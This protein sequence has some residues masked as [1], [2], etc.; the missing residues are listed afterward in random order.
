MRW[1]HFFVIVLFAGAI[2]V[3][4]AQNFQIVTMSFFGLSA[5]LP[6]AVLAVIIYLAGTVTGSSLL[7]LLR[8]SLEGASRRKAF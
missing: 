7:A 2:I 8:R 1:I 6:L 3:F 5:T 4:V